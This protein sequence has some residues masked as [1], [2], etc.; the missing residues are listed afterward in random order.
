MQVVK[1]LAEA[2]AKFYADGSL[3]DSLN[4]NRKSAIFEK[5]IENG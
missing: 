4:Q 5:N 2:S 3:K 1:N